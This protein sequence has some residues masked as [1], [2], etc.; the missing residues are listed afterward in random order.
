MVQFGTFF[1]LSVLKYIAR[2]A[3][4]RLADGVERG[5]SYGL[6]LSGLEYGE[7]GLRYANLIGQFAR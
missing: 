6:G 1:Y 4:Q 5:E 2:L 3:V 7:V